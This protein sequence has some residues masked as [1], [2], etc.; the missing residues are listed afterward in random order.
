MLPVKCASCFQHCASLLSY[1]LLLNLCYPCSRQKLRNSGEKSAR[2]RTSQTLAAVPTSRDRRVSERGAE[3]P[4][5][6]CTTRSPGGSVVA[7]VLPASIL[8]RA[9]PLKCNKH[10][11]HRTGMGKDGE[12]QAGRRAHGAAEQ[13]HWVKFSSG[14]SSGSRSSRCELFSCLTLSLSV[15]QVQGQVL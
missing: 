11:K 15:R 1:A 12:D 8:A 6:S 13:I 2:A 4:P 9:F 3:N 10:I 5:A 7:P 14:S